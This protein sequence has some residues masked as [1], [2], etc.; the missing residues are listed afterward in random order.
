MKSAEMYPEYQG[1]PENIQFLTRAEHFE[2]H[3]CNWRNPTNWY[4]NPTTKEKTDFGDGKFIP[5]EIIWLAESLINPRNK[6]EVGKFSIQECVNE[7]Q[8]KAEQITKN[9]SLQ[10]T[11]PPKDNNEVDK[12]KQGFGQKL[13][14][15]LKTI[16]KTIVKFPERHPT[17]MKVIKGVGIL[18]TV[19]AAFVAESSRKGSSDSGYGQSDD[20]DDYAYDNYACDEYSSEDSERPYTPNDVPAGRQRYHYKDGSTRW[21]ET[22]SYHRDGKKDE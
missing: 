14:S 11:V 13:E 20:R 8:K 19:T 2:S 16:R 10:M 4:F 5:C 18:V 17:T 22:P 21:K 9:K 15:G 6:Q 7:A 1:D 12:T 3:D